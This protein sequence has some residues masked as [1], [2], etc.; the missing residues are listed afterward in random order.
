[1]KILLKI[2]LVVVALLAPISVLVVRAGGNTQ[3][4]YSVT[5]LGPGSAFKAGNLD[6][7]GTFLVVG[8]SPDPA[9]P[10]GPGLATVWTVTTDGTVVNVFTYD[11]LGPSAAVDVSDHG[12]I[13]GNTGRGAFVDVPGVGVATLP[14]AL[15]AFGV[16]NHGAVVGYV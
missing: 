10:N 7:S 9:N 8:S 4:L 1:M 14:N 3:T 16:N 5:N 15:N 11:S 12:M 6:S 2:G 13:V